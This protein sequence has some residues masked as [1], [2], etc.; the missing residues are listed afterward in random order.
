MNP[1]LLEMYSEVF[2]ALAHPTRLAILLTLAQGDRCVCELVEL[3]DNDFSNTSKHLTLL[4]SA[5]V[6]SKTKDGK[7][8]IYH[9]EM[10][11]ILTFLSCLEHTLNK[12]LH[13]KINLF[14][15][16]PIAKG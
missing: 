11:C 10:P 9:L 3:F 8:V 4:N 12:H 13:D 16:N 7:K 1:E 15:T 2:K 14:T 5:G 6:V